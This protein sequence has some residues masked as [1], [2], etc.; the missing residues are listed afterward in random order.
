MHPPCQKP[1]RS[2]FGRIP[3]LSRYCDKRINNLHSNKEI[4]ARQHG[5]PAQRVRNRFTQETLSAPGGF[6]ASSGKHPPPP[7]LGLFSLFSEIPAGT[8]LLVPAPPGETKGSFR[9]AEGEG[10]KVGQPRKGGV[11]ALGLDELRMRPRSI[12]SNEPAHSPEKMRKSRP[13]RRFHRGKVRT[14]TGADGRGEGRPAPRTTGNPPHCL[15]ALEKEEKVLEALG[16][17]LPSLGIPALQGLL[18]LA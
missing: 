14:A 18:Q 17:L 3:S 10:K 2:P 9:G 16:G 13:L 15:S 4:P 7:F 11:E 6:H 12:A 5:D 8:P 1:F